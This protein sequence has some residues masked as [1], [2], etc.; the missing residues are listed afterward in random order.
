MIPVFSGRWDELYLFAQCIDLVKRGE[1]QVILIEGEAGIGK[2]A[3]LKALAAAIQQRDERAAR[4]FTLVAPDEG[5][6]DP[7]LEAVLAVTAKRVYDRV[8]GKREAKDLLFEWIGAI[9]GVGDFAAAVGAT[10]DAVHRRWRQAN[11]PGAPVDED[12]EALLLTA[13]RPLTL[14]FDDLHRADP[15][16]IAR[17]EV[18]IR[19][20]VRGTRLLLVGMY[21][22]AAPRA[23]PPAIRKLIDTLPAGSVRHRK[24][25]ALTAKEMNL[26]LDK[27]FPRAARS[28]AFLDWLSDSTGGHPATIERTLAHLLDQSLIRF[29][30]SH[31]EIDPDPERLNVPQASDPVVDLGGITPEIT[32]IVLAASV[33]GEDFDGSTLAQLL[34]QDELYVE[35]QLALAVHHGLV[36]ITGET[37]LPD[38]EIATLYRF[39]TP[40]LRSTLYHSLA[41]DHR[42]TLEQR[43]RGETAAA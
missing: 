35:D 32:E 20:S 17:L 1:P 33:L 24:L 12:I 38:G 18:L 15:E 43:K 40:Y 13:R 26:W 30:N 27:Q 10:M 3:L 39:A 16:A 31:W 22:P 23:V 21:C 29:V 37:T 8:G 7:I 19:A 2:T 25:R 5:R 4:V 41:A 6:Y 28:A 34:D 9:P 36:E 14:L 11:A 42:T